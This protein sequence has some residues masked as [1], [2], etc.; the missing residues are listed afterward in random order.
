M[1]I[2]TLGGGLLAPFEL[3]YGLRIAHLS[4]T[5]A[6]LVLS[7]AGAAGIVT[8][9]L[10]GAAVDRVGPARVVAAANA[11]GATG[12]AT[13]LLWPNALGYGAGMFLR[14]EEHNV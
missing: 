3:V 11:L 1:F 13:L 14:S 8:G 10:A 2:D 9:P 12:C 7:L 4:L 6:G 5:G